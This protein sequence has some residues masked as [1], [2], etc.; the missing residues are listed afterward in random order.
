MKFNRRL[1]REASDGSGT[2][3]REDIVD[4]LEALVRIRNGKGVVDDI[5]HLG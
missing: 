1:G 3:D 2:L 4:V 5:D